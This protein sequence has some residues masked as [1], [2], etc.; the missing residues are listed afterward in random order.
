MQDAL[1]PLLAATA[2]ADADPALRGHVHRLVEELG[3]VA[4]ATED[5]IPPALR[6]R[7]KALTEATEAGP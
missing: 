3:V 1:A 4:G 2:A 5:D 7:L 6:G